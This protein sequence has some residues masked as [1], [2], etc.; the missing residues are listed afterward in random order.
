[1]LTAPRIGQF[2]RLWYAERKRCDH[3]HHGRLGVVQVVAKGPGPR[4]HG[5]LLVRSGDNSE[6]GAGVPAGNLQPVQPVNFAGRSFLIHAF[7][8]RGRWTA[9]YTSASIWS[10]AYWRRNRGGYARSPH[11]THW[12]HPLGTSPNREA[13]VELAYAAIQLQHGDATCRE[14]IN[15]VRDHSRRNVKTPWERHCDDLRRQRKIGE[16]P[17]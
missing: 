11:F 13:A 6:V 16:V 1:M 10:I 4:N 14:T 2:V 5:I 15:P 9:E 12:K 7:S 8:V 17:A 3:P